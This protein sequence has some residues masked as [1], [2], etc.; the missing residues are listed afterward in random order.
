M[1]NALAC[2]GWVGS[3][4][5]DH[6]DARLDATCASACPTDMPAP[7]LSPGATATAPPGAALRSLA[8]PVSQHQ[9]RALQSGAGPLTQSAAREWLAQLDTPIGPAANSRQLPPSKTQLA[10]SAAVRAQVAQAASDFWHG[11]GSFAPAG[12]DHQGWLSAVKDTG[13]AAWNLGVDVLALAEMA[14]PLDATR[15]AAYRSIGIELPTASRWRATYDTPA[16]GLTLEVLAPLVPA[17]RL[18]GS[19]HA[20]GGAAFVE[21]KFVHS[22]V[23][24]SNLELHGRAITRMPEEAL[25]LLQ[26]VGHDPEVLAEYRIVKLSGS[27]YEFRA[28]RLRFHFDATYGNVPDSAQSVSFHRNIAS[29][30]VDG[31]TKIPVYV[32]EQVFDSDEAI[33]QVL[34]HEILETQELKYLAAKP[35]SISEYKSLVRPDRAGNLHWHAVQEGD[36]WLQNFRTLLEGKN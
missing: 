11:T 27:D 19:P 16:F 36:A 17:R 2:S 28:S 20:L 21:G 26:R 18:L 33:I 24:R 15:R 30:M 9:H 23:P 1:L 29:R 14:D 8:L 7:D 34:S 5:S 32:R 3:R 12:P 31:T 4:A 10:S 13:R 35:I 22:L 25:Q 6:L